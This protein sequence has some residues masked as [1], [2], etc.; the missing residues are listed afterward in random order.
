DPAVANLEGV[1]IANG[2]ISTGESD[3]KFTGEGTFV[4]WSGV[5]LQRDFEDTR[6]NTEPVEVFRYRPDFKLNLPGFLRRPT[7][8]W[9]EVAP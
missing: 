8:E 5:N 6:N 9:Q 1:Y 4:G 2:T 7:I 3:T